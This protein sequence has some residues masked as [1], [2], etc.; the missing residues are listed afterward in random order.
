MHSN[1]RLLPEDI[2]CKS[3]QRNNIRRANTCDPALKLLIEEITLDIQKLKQNIGKEH[4][5]AHW[6]HRHNTHTLWKTIHGPSNRA[7]QRALNTSITF[8]N[9]IATTP[10]HI[11]NCFTK[12][13]T[14]TVKHATHKTNRHINRATHNIE[15]YNITL[16]T[17]QVQEVT[18]QSKNNHS[19]GPDKLNIRH[20]KH[21]GPLGLAFLTSMFKTALN[22]NII[23][24]SWKLANIVPIPKP[25]KDTDKGTSYRP[26][27]FLSVIA[28]TGEECS[29]LHYRNHNKHTHA[30]QVQNTTLYSDGTTHSKQ[31]RSKG[32]Q[33]NDSPCANNHCSTR[34]EQSFRHNKHTH[35]NKKTATDQ[36]SMHNH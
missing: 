21:I 12:Q 22:K 5:D 6:D 32:V 4:L 17:S 31:H 9:K 23:P 27:S 19:Q 10:K 26:I 33:P 13:F 25:N 7:P 14:N 35:T 34:Y 15:G 11:A 3:T 18:K 16:T 2:V 30:T 20:L 24:H 1:C 29:S 36:H 8:N 28:D